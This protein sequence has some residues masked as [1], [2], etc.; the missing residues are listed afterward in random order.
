MKVLMSSCMV[1][2]PYLPLEIELSFRMA[3]VTYNTASFPSLIRTLSEVI[4]LGNK[5]TIVLMGYKERDVAE[6]TLWSLVSEIGL[7]LE[8]VGMHP[9]AG[10]VPVEIWL[11]RGIGATLK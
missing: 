8:K 7:D 6:R 5:P 4:C 9:G 3:D 11:G 10:G 1:F 2:I